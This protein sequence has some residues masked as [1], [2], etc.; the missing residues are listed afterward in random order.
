MRFK[1]CNKYWYVRIKMPRLKTNYM[2][3]QRKTEHT[4]CV[5]IPAYIVETANLKKGD[6][7]FFDYELTNTGVIIRFKK[8]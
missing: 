6:I 3:I 4:L 7:V 5:S 1:F 8:K 2:I